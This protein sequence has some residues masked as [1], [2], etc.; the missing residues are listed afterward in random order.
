TRSSAT[1]GRPTS[2]SGSPGRSTPPSRTRPSVR[3]V[4]FEGVGRVGVADV[5]D[6]EILAPGDAIV[7]VTTTAICGSDLHFFHGK[8]P[9]DPGEVLGHEA[10]GVVETTGDDVRL[11]HP[12]DR[13]VVSFHV[14][15]GRCWFCRRGETS[16]CDDH[17]ILGAGP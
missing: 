5:P 8:A 1:C 2:S 10:V 6:P 12:G 15:C 14:A 17:A 4:V 7:R 3:A 16:L 13:V 9:I 11:V